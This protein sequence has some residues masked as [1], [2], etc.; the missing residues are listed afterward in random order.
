MLGRDSRD[1]RLVD[2]QHARHERREVVVR[3]PVERELRGAAADLLGRLEVPR[4]AA[5]EPRASR[6]ELLPRDRPFAAD[7]AELRQRFEDRVAVTSD[8]TLAWSANGPG[9]RRKSNDV[10]APYV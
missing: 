7:G 3:Q 2:R 8:W 9:P 1:I 10:R 6:F 4:I 5:R